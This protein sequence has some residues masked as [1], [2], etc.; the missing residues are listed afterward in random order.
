MKCPTCE[1][2]TNR[3]HWLPSDCIAALK[4][5]R[6]KSR[7]TVITN[8]GP[9]KNIHRAYLAIEEYHIA[10]WCPT[11]DPADSKPEQVHMEIKV[12]GIPHQ[13]MMRFKSRRSLELMTGTLLEH[14]EGVWPTSK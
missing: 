13:L 8:T 9:E 11:P 1:L 10:Q 2:K 14:A 12:A 3:K 5:D 4:S 6:A 7:M